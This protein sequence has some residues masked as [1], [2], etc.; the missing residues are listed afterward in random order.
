MAD[1]SRTPELVCDPGPA[2]ASRDR[3]VCRAR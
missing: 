1:G 3:P 2:V